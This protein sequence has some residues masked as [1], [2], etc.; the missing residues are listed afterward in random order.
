MQ[1]P[2]IPCG[3]FPGIPHCDQQAP[4]GIEV[5]EYVEISMFLI[6]DQ[7]SMKLNSDT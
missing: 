7:Y 2:K 5:T 3:E 1:E 4:K 6:T